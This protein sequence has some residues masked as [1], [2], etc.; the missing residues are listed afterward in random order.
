MS[1][2]GAETRPSERRL[3]ASQRTVLRWVLRIGVAATFFGHGM[4]AWNVHA[5]WIPYLT[6]V[7]F[8]AEAAATI[9]PVIGMVDF[10]VGAV[11]LVRPIRL[12][13]LY[14]VVWTLATA[15]IRPLAGEAPG[16]SWSGAQTGRLRW[17]CCCCRAS[18]PSG[19]ISFGRS[20]E[21]YPRPGDT[22]AP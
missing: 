4:F 7:G 18:R 10:T 13:V 15:L 21:R 3:S 9:M 2:Q 1:E 16:P 5:G 14:A 20:S 19:G 17:H 6:T 8:S 12:V 11:V 22:A